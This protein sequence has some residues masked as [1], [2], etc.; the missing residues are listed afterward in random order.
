MSNKVGN[1][2]SPKPQNMLKGMRN[3]HDKN[4]HDCTSQTKMT[5]FS[6]KQS[7][8]SPQAHA[9]PSVYLKKPGRGSV[10]SLPNNI[11]TN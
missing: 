2:C 6:E 7:Q 1:I 9:R 8:Q 10:K 4:A 5:K 3:A 11:K